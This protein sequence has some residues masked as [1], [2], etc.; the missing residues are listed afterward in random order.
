MILTLCIRPVCSC[1]R[2]RLTLPVNSSRLKHV[3][4]LDG[5]GQ[6]G[7]G[8][9]HQHQRQA[10]HHQHQRQARHH[11]HHNADMCAVF[12]IGKT[13]GVITTVWQYFIIR[14]YNSKHIVILHLVQLYPSFNLR[15]LVILFPIVQL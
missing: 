5:H 15:P 3:R 2:P 10:R 11:Q 6:L 14:S 9:G 7:P 4:K 12:V 13:T 1:S 8:E